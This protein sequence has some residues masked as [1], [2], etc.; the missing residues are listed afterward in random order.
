[1]PCQRPTEAPSRDLNHFHP[2]TGARHPGV[3]DAPGRSRTLPDVFRRRAGPRLQI[4]DLETWRCS[5][6][7]A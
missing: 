6:A 5:H 2:A 3:P 4:R 7:R 1:V